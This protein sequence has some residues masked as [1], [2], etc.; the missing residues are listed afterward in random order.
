LSWA[1]SLTSLNEGDPTYASRTAASLTEPVATFE[2]R[3][4]DGVVEVG[5]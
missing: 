2:I 3:V 1:T 5:L 4:H